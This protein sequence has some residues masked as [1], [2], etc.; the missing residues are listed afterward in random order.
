LQEKAAG[1]F[2]AVD[3]AIEQTKQH[4]EKLLAFKKGLLNELI[5]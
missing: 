1:L 3:N 4:R 5:G 2:E